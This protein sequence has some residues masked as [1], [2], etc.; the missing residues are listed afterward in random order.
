MSE[1]VRK[2]ER[3]ATRSSLHGRR[4]IEKSVTDGDKEK[5][6]YSADEETSALSTVQTSVSVSGAEGGFEPEDVSETPDSEPH[7]SR[8]EKIEYK[9][10]VGPQHVRH[11]IT[12]TKRH[13]KKVRIRSLEHIRQRLDEP[14]DE[15]YLRM[16]SDNSREKTKVKESYCHEASHRHDIHTTSKIEGDELHT[17]IHKTQI[18]GSGSSGSGMSSPDIPG[19]YETPIVQSY[20]K[21]LALSQ[22]SELSRPRV[23]IKKEVSE[24]TKK[25]KRSA[26]SHFVQETYWKEIQ[27]QGESK[28]AYEETPIVDTISVTSITSTKALSPEYNSEAVERNAEDPVTDGAGALS[29]VVQFEPVQDDLSAPSHEI[30]EEVEFRLGAYPEEPTSSQSSIHE[31]AQSIRTEDLDVRR[32]YRSTQVHLPH[33]DED[34]VVQ[35]TLNIPNLQS[36]IADHADDFSKDRIRTSMVITSDAAKTRTL[37]VE[38]FEDEDSPNES[39]TFLIKPKYK[40]LYSMDVARYSSDSGEDVEAYRGQI[41]QPIGQ[42]VQYAEWETSSSSGSDVDMAELGGR[43]SSRSQESPEFEDHGSRFSG[44]GHDSLGRESTDVM[45]TPE[46]QELDQEQH[47]A[48]AQPDHH[49]QVEEAEGYQSDDGS[50]G[51]SS[52]EILEEVE[53]AEEDRENI[54]EYVSVKEDSNEGLSLSTEQVVEVA[55]EFSSQVEDPS[56]KGIS[57]SQYLD[58]VNGRASNIAAEVVDEATSTAVS[59]TSPAGEGTNEETDATSPTSTDLTTAQQEHQPGVE[60]LVERMLADVFEQSGILIERHYGEIQTEEM[61]ERSSETTDH[62]QQVQGPRYVYESPASGS[63]SESESER[64]PLPELPGA[65]ALYTMRRTRAGASSLGSESLESI[66]TSTLSSSDL[67]LSF[68]STTA[69]SDFEED[70]VLKFRTLSRAQSMSDYEAYQMKHK[71]KTTDDF[72]AEENE[73]YQVHKTKSLPLISGSTDDQEEEPPKEDNLSLS[74]PSLVPEESGEEFPTCTVSQT[75]ITM[76]GI[77]ADG[78]MQTS[79]Q[80]HDTFFGPYEVTERYTYESEIISKSTDLEDGQK[81]QKEIEL[82]AQEVMR[83]EMTQTI[84][85]ISI[86]DDLHLEE[87]TQ[88][89]SKSDPKGQKYEITIHDHL[90]LYIDETDGAHAKEKSVL[91]VPEG[92]E[93]SHKTSS[94]GSSE[95]RKMIIV[96]SVEKLELVEEKSDNTT[97]TDGTGPDDMEGDLVPELRLSFLT[98]EQLGDVD[99][100]DLIAATERIQQLYQSEPRQALLSFPDSDDSRL[101]PIMEEV[102]ETSI[103]PTKKDKVSPASSEELVDILGKI[104]KASSDDAPSQDILQYSSPSDVSSEMDIVE[105]VI[106]DETLLQQSSRHARSSIDRIEELLAEYHDKAEAPDDKKEET[107]D[108]AVKRLQE[109]KMEYK[110]VQKSKPKVD[111]SG[112][113]QSPDALYANLSVREEQHR[114]HTYQTLRAS[115]RLEEDEGD[116]LEPVSYRMRVSQEDDYLEPS[117]TKTENVYED[118]KEDVYDDIKAPI[119][120]EYSKDDNIYEDVVLPKPP[121]L[122][123]PTRKSIKEEH[124]DDED[125]DDVF[126]ERRDDMDKYFKDMSKKTEDGSGD[127]VE[128]PETRRLAG[129]EKEMVIGSPS[130]LPIDI[131]DKTPSDEPL[132]SRR[133][134]LLNDEKRMV[135]KESDDHSDKLNLTGEIHASSDLELHESM[136]IEAEGGPDIGENDEVSTIEVP[137]ARDLRGSFAVDGNLPENIFTPKWDK[138]ITVIEKTSD[139]LTIPAQKGDLERVSTEER[140]SSLGKSISLQRALGK[141]KVV[142]YL[143]EQAGVQSL[144]NALTPSL[145]VETGSDN[146]KEDSP[147]SSTVQSLELVEVPI[148]L[149]DFEAKESVDLVTSTP[150]RPTTPDQTMQHETVVS[151]ALVSPTPSKARVSELTMF[152]DTL[153]SKDSTL[154]RLAHENV[155]DIIGDWTF[156]NLEEHELMKQYQTQDITVSDKPDFEQTSKTVQYPTNEKDDIIVEKSQLSLQSVDYG[157]LMKEPLQLAEHPDRSIDGKGDETDIAIT[158]LERIG[159][160]TVEPGSSMSRDI[161]F[162]SL[163]GETQDVFEDNSDDDA[164]YLEVLPIPTVENDSEDFPKRKTTALPDHVEDGYVVLR[165]IDKSTLEVETKSEDYDQLKKVEDD[166]DYQSSK[167]SEGV[168]SEGDDEYEDYE[169]LNVVRR[170]ILSSSKDEDEYTI[171][172]LTESNKSVIMASESTEPSIQTVG[173]AV[174]TSKKE[175]DDISMESSDS[176]LPSPPPTP[177]PNLHP[178]RPDSGYITIPSSDD[179]YSLRSGESSRFNT[180][181]P[182]VQRVP[183]IANVD[184]TIHDDEQTTEDAPVPKKELE[185]SPWTPTLERKV[186]YERAATKVLDY[187]IDA[188]PDIEE[189]HRDLNISTEDSGWIS[190]SDDESVKEVV[191]PFPAVANQTMQPEDLSQRVWESEKV[192][193]NEEVRFKA[194]L[195]P[196]PGPTQIVFEEDTK[197]YESAESEEGPLEEGLCPLDVTWTPTLERK[198]RYERAIELEDFKMDALPEKEPNFNLSADDTMLSVGSEEMETRDVA[199]PFIPATA[200]LMQSENL[201]QKI[202]DTT[203]EEEMSSEP[204]LKPAPG[205]TQILFEGDTIDYESAES[206]EEHVEPLGDRVCPLDVT[207]TPTLE[208]KAR[209]ERAIK[210]EDYKIDTLPEIGDNQLDLNLSTDDTVVSSEAEEVKI[211][212]VTHPFIAATTERMQSDNLLQRIED[213]TTPEEMSSKLEL[214]PAT[215]KTQILFEEVKEKKVIIIPRVEVSEEEAALPMSNEYIEVLPNDEELVEGVPLQPL[216]SPPTSPFEKVISQ[217]HEYITLISDESL[218]QRESKKHEEE[219]DYEILKPRASQTQHESEVQ[220]DNDYMMVISDETRIQSEKIEMEEKSDYIALIPDES[221]TQLGKGEVEEDHEYI[222]VIPGVYQTQSESTIETEHD[223]IKVITEKGET[224]PGKEDIKEDSEYITV[225]P[226]EVQTQTEKMVEADHEYIKLLPDESEIQPVEDD[227]EYKI[228]LADKSQIKEREQEYI[229]LKADEIQTQVEVKDVRE[230]HEYITLIHDEIPSQPQRKEVQED[231]EYILVSD[232]IQTQPEIKKVKEEEHEYITLISE[233]RGTEADSPKITQLPSSASSESDLEPG[234]VIIKPQS[235]RSERTEQWVQSLPVKVQE[236]EENVE[237]HIEKSTLTAPESTSAQTSSPHWEVLDKEVVI[238]PKDSDLPLM[239]KEEHILQEKVPGHVVETEKPVYVESDAKQ[240]VSTTTLPG[241]IVEALPYSQEM[242]VEHAELEEYEHRAVVP[243]LVTQEETIVPAPPEISPPRSPPAEAVEDDQEH[244]LT[245]DDESPAQEAPPLLKSILKTSQKSF[246]EEDK[247]QIYTLPTLKSSPEFTRLEVKERSSIVIPEEDFPQEAI[248]DAPWPKPLFIEQDSEQMPDVEQFSEKVETMDDDYVMPLSVYDSPMPSLEHAEV[249]EDEAYVQT[250]YDENKSLPSVAYYES[251]PQEI[252]ALE[253]KYNLEEKVNV[254]S[255]V[256][257]PPSPKSGHSPLI[258][259]L[260]RPLPLEKEPKLAEPQSSESLVVEMDTQKESVP[261]VQDTVDDVHD[262]IE[263]IP[264]DQPPTE[265]VPSPPA[266]SPPRSPPVDKDQDLEDHG[267]IEALPDYQSTTQDVPSL[268]KLSPKSPSFDQKVEEVQYDLPVLRPPPDTKPTSLREIIQRKRDYGEEYISDIVIPT[269]VE[270]SPEA[271]QAETQNDVAE[272]QSST[273]TSVSVVYVEEAETMP[274]KEVPYPIT[275]PLTPKLEDSNQ[276]QLLP[277]EESVSQQI[278]SPP[279]PLTIPIKDSESE[280]I[281]FHAH[282]ETP[283]KKT[284]HSPLVSKLRR[285]LPLEKDSKLKEHDDEQSERSYFSYPEDASSKRALQFE[286]PSP[287]LPQIPS[288][289]V[290]APESKP[291]IE[292]NEHSTELF[293]TVQSNEMVDESN[294]ITS[295]PW[296]PAIERV[297][298]SDQEISPP[299][300]LDAKTAVSPSFVFSTKKTQATEPKEKPLLSKPRRALPLEKELESQEIDFVEIIPGKKSKDRDISVEL[301]T[302]KSTFSPLRP[303]LVGRDLKVEE[304]DEA[305]FDDMHGFIDTVP[306]EYRIDMEVPPSPEISPTRS[307]PADKIP[308]IEPADIG[309]EHE[310]VVKSLLKPQTAPTSRPYYK[311]DSKESAQEPSLEVSGQELSDS[312]IPSLPMSLAPS[313]LV[314][315]SQQYTADEDRQS[316]AIVSPSFVF[317]TK[318]SQQKEQKEKPLLSKPRRA[319]PLEKDV[320]LEH[321]YGHSEQAIISTGKE[322]SIVIEEKD[323]EP[324]HDDVLEL[325]YID[326]IPDEYVSEMEIPPLPEISPPRSPPADETE[327][328]DNQYPDRKSV[329]PPLLQPKT[330]KPDYKEVVA[331]RSALPVL[332]PS[333]GYSPISIRDMVDKKVVILSSEESSQEP[334]AVSADNIDDEK[335]ESVPV[336]DTKEQGMV[337]PSFVFSTKKVQSPDIEVSQIDYQS[338]ENKAQTAHSSLI[339]E[340]RKLLPLEKALKPK[341]YEINEVHTEGYEREKLIPEEKDQRR[342][343]LEV[344]EFLPS[345]KVIFSPPQSAKVLP[346]EKSVEIVEPRKLKPIFYDEDKIEIQTGV[347]SFTEPVDIDQGYDVKSETTVP[348]P[349]AYSPPRSPPVEVTIQDF[350]MVTQNEQSLQKSQ[351]YGEDKIDIQTGVT[352]FTESVEF[353]QEALENVEMAIP[354]PPATSPPRSPP[355]EAMH[356]E[357]DFVMVTSDEQSLPQRLVYDE[358]RI[359]IRTDVAR[360]PQSMDLNQE[361]IDNVEMAIPTPLQTSPPRSPPAEVTLHDKNKYVMII[362]EEHSQPEK[363]VLHASVSSTPERFIVHEKLDHEMELAEND[364]EQSSKYDD[365]KKRIPTLYEYI[366]KTPQPDQVQRDSGEVPQRY[367]LPALKPSPK[368]EPTSLR[369]VIERKVVILPKEETPEETEPTFSIESQVA[370]EHHVQAEEL[371]YNVD[372][373]EK[374]LSSG[375]TSPLIMPP[376]EKVQMYE[377]QEHIQISA[378]DENKPQTEYSTTSVSSNVDTSVATALKIEQSLNELDEVLQIGAGQAL[379]VSHQTDTEVMQSQP[380]VIHHIEKEVRLIEPKKQIPISEHSKR[381]EIVQLS[382]LEKTKQIERDFRRLD[383]SVVVS[384]AQEKERETH[385]SPLQ[386]SQFIEEELRL[387]EPKKVNKIDGTVS[388]SEKNKL[389]TMEVAETKSQQVLGSSQKEKSSQLDD[390][391]ILEPP[392]GWAP[393]SL[394][395]VI[396]RNIA[397]SKEKTSEDVVPTQDMTSTKVKVS[398]K[399]I[400]SDDPITDTSATDSRVIVLDVSPNIESSQQTPTHMEEVTSVSLEE[401]LPPL[402]SVEMKQEYQELKYTPELIQVISDSTLP[403]PQPGP[404]LGQHERVTGNEAI[405]SLKLS[406]QDRVVITSDEKKQ[407]AFAKLVSPRPWT[408]PKENLKIVE[409]DPRDQIQKP[410]KAKAPAPPVPSL[411]TKRPAPQ[412]PMG[413]IDIVDLDSVEVLPTSSP[414]DPLKDEPKLVLP[415]MTTV[416]PSPKERDDDIPPLFELVKRM[417]DSTHEYDEGISVQISP[418]EPSGSSSSPL[419]MVM[420]QE[421]HAFAESHPI[422]YSKA[423]EK[424][425]S[426]HA[427]SKRAVS[428]MQSE[429]L[430]EEMAEAVI[431]RDV[432]HQPITPTP[433]RLQ[434]QEHVESSKQSSITESVPVKPGYFQITSSAA[435]SPYKPYKWKDIEVDQEPEEVPKEAPSKIARSLRDVIR[436]AAV[437]EFA[438]GKQFQPVSI[439]DELPNSS[440]ESMEEENYEKLHSKVSQSDSNESVHRY[441]QLIPE[442]IQSSSNESMQGYEIL[443]PFDN[444]LSSLESVPGHSYEKVPHEIIELPSDTSPSTKSEEIKQPLVVADFPKTLTQVKEVTESAPRAMYQQIQEDIELP[445]TTSTVKR[446]EFDEPTLELVAHEAIGKKIVEPTLSQE[447]AEQEMVESI[448]RSSPQELRKREVIESTLLEEVRKQEYVEALPRSSPK[449][450]DAIGSIPSSLSD[451]AKKQEVTESILFE[452]VTKQKVIE[453]IPWT[454]P[455]IKQQEVI[456]TT[457][458][459]SFSPEDKQHEEVQEFITVSE[460]ST[461]ESFPTFSRTDPKEVNIEVHD[462]PVL[463][464]PKTKVPTFYRDFAGKSLE[465]VEK[466]DPLE[467]D[468][469]QEQLAPSSTVEDT[470]VTPVSMEG[471]PVV[472]LFEEVTKQKVI[473]SIPW[474]LPQIKQEEVIET[475]ERAS[476]SPEYKQHEEV[477]EFITVSESSTQESY[478]TFSRTDSKEVNTQVHDSPVLQLPKTKVPTFYR[479]FAGKNLEIVEKDDAL[480]VDSLK[481]QWAPSSTVEDTSVTPVSVEEVPVV[482]ISHQTQESPSSDTAPRSEVLHS[483]TQTSEVHGYVEEHQVI[484]DESERAYPTNERASFFPE[485]EEHKEVQEFISVSETSTQE[486]FPTFSRTDSKE[487]NTQVHDSPVLAFPKTKV[488]T[489]YRDF[490][491]KRLEI[492]EKD[493]TLIGDSLQEQWASSSTVED[494]SVTPANMEEAPV[495]LISHQTQESSSSDTAPRSQVLHTITQTSEVHEYVEELQVIADESERSYPKALSKDPLPVSYY[496]DKYLSGSFQESKEYEEVQRNEDVVEY[497]PQLSQTPES[498]SEKELVSQ[499]QFQSPSVSHSFEESSRMYDSAK[500]ETSENEPERPGPVTLSVPETPTDLLAENIKQRDELPQAGPVTMSIPETPSD[501]LSDSIKQSDKPS[502][503]GPLTISVPEKTTDLLSDS[504]KQGEEISWAGPVTKSVPEIPTDLLSENIKQSDELPQPGPAVMSVPEKPTDLLSDNLKQYDEVSRPGPVIMSLPE[505]PTDLLSDNKRRSDEFTQPGPVIMSVPETPTDLL[506]DNSRQSDELIQPGP[507]TVSVPETPID[508]LS[509]NRRRS[510]SSRQSSFSS[511]SEK[512]VVIISKDESQSDTTYQTSSKKRSR[513][514]SPLGTPPSKTLKGFPSPRPTNRS[515]PPPKHTLSDDELDS[516]TVVPRALKRPSVNEDV[517]KVPSSSP[518]RTRESIIKGE[519]PSPVAS[520]KRT[521][522]SEKFVMTGDSSFQ[523]ASYEESFV[524]VQEDHVVPRKIERTV[525]TLEEDAKEYQLKV[526]SQQA[527]PDIEKGVDVSSQVVAD[528]ERNEIISPHIVPELERAVKP[529]ERAFPVQERDTQSPEPHEAVKADLSQQ[530]VPDLEL[531]PNAPRQVF[532]SDEEIDTHMFSDT[533]S[534]PEDLQ[535]EAEDAIV[536]TKVTKNLEDWPVTGS[537][538]VSAMI[539]TRP[540]YRM[541]DEELESDEDRLSGGESRIDGEFV[542]FTDTGTVAKFESTDADM[543]RYITLLPGDDELWAKENDDDLEVSIRREKVLAEWRKRKMREHEFDILPKDTILLARTS[544]ASNSEHRWRVI[545]LDHTKSLRDALTYASS[546]SGSEVSARD[547]LM[548]DDYELHWDPK[549][550]PADSSSLDPLLEGLAKKG[551]F[552]LSQGE[553]LDFSQSERHAFTETYVNTTLPASEDQADFSRSRV[554]STIGDVDNIEFFQD[555]TVELSTEGHI[556]QES[557]IHVEEKEVGE[558]AKVQDIQTA[559]DVKSKA[560]QISEQKR[561]LEIERR[562]RER[563]LNQDFD[564]LPQDDIITYGSEF[565]LSDEEIK[566]QSLPNDHSKSLRDALNYYAQSI[567]LSRSARKKVEEFFDGPERRPVV[568]RKKSPSH[569]VETSLSREASLKSSSSG[570]SLNEDELEMGRARGHQARK[571]KRPHRSSKKS[572][573]SRSLR[574]ETQ[575]HSDERDSLAYELSFE[576]EKSLIHDQ[577]LGVDGD[578]NETG[579]YDMTQAPTTLKASGRKA[580]ESLVPPIPLQ[581][582]PAAGARYSQMDSDYHVDSEIPSDILDQS[583]LSS[584]FEP[585]ERRATFISMDASMEEAAPSP[586]R[587]KMAPEHPS[588]ITAS[589]FGVGTMVSESHTSTSTVDRSIRTRGVQRPTPVS[590]ADWGISTKGAEY[591]PDTHITASDF[592]V[593]TRGDEQVTSITTTEQGVRSKD[594]EYLPNI[595]ATDFGYQ[596]RGTEFSPIAASD[597]GL[598]TIDSEHTQNITARN[599]GYQIKDTEQFSPIT[600]SDWG[601]RTIDSEHSQNI[602]ARDFGYQIKDTE[603]FSPITSPDWGFRTMGSEYSPNI[604]AR[605]FGYQTKDTE[606]FSPIDTSNWILKAKDSELSPN[607]TASDFGYMTRGVEQFS[608]ISA[609]D[610]GMRTLGAEQLGGMAIQ[611]QTSITATDFGVRANATDQL[612]TIGGTEQLFVSTTDWGARSMVSGPSSPINAIDWRARSRIS[613]QMSPIY[614]SDWGARTRIAGQTSPIYATDWGASTRHPNPRQLSSP[615]TVTD[616]GSRTRVRVGEGHSSSRQKE[617]ALDRVSVL[618][619]DKLVPFESLDSSDETDEVV[620]FTTTKASFDESFMSSGSSPMQHSIPQVNVVPFD[621]DC[622]FESFHSGSYIEVSSSDSEEMRKRL[623]SS[624]EGDK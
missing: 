199:Q 214:R 297:M 267:F 580:T 507:V 481:E 201:L 242:H 148:D 65:R 241:K 569:R 386:T 39:G 265:S 466:D 256:D 224:E 227:R 275:K 246:S 477:Q 28:Q 153:K 120:K 154:S 311:E 84:P 244:M 70:E 489:F 135:V 516:A 78:K 584:T 436:G 367:D 191:H 259:K 323:R 47:L 126:M 522:K 564:I 283:T 558:S 218:T 116:Y 254:Q 298:L 492:V 563:Y 554:D 447:A 577:G 56:P 525:S 478:P 354:T 600:A 281:E 602:I 176:S 415:E 594:S 317:T 435:T 508:L 495:V 193:V 526:I 497:H 605:D 618:P 309:D 171:L 166:E 196:A 589:D 303:L 545:P 469:L 465:I 613:G 163:L 20:M 125:E 121:S 595:T 454:L 253:E 406:S 178:I 128:S 77:E 58:E 26:D 377:D 306:V 345:K 418:S 568:Y 48:E 2:E 103:H 403:K 114:E 553:S 337:S 506:P 133:R 500:T 216:S 111:E 502:L 33:N 461:Q 64:Q 329:K 15:Q 228:I 225:I 456:D 49:L 168:A 498:L 596:T 79:P 549:A 235:E 29:P 67:A 173:E 517:S 356:D 524:E 358:D 412:P 12:H 482:L 257:V 80:K 444:Q 164:G 138:D 324:I 238:V 588:F 372:H 232:E 336:L 544:T 87:Q 219:S 365:T 339:S 608:P 606:Q 160:L 7:P 561:R 340:P 409:R 321:D 429:D 376:L 567:G 237:T 385:L 333:P 458:R 357:L 464:L 230:D 143:E 609:T 391:P 248:P 488:P 448:P 150:A 401:S 432:S 129:Q 211:R 282:V 480:E 234:Y 395:D 380:E 328:I 13:N 162:A 17:T 532:S 69:D 400:S 439:N 312:V 578:D 92:S 95:S 183:S 583:F 260:R 562:R 294:L 390:L 46:L 590:A 206:E 109:L 104:E 123:K 185:G 25:E 10:Q 509:D 582:D 585:E 455:Q 122:G 68:D 410:K 565:R 619:N 204:E 140:E 212:D 205:Q 251:S 543:H 181:S 292:Q 490:A 408:L 487:V 75:H 375:I 1:R 441:Q 136:F 99:E 157:A 170:P 592:V 550:F 34:S 468:S 249:Y 289:S 467:V 137:P 397:L 534:E 470:S 100:E 207:W 11:E 83:V 382:P 74:M 475:T 586:S 315:E 451:E 424:I 202:E 425:L 491:G 318:K 504:I 474:T 446:L 501:L 167:A 351:I 405:T 90:E 434:V 293:E 437:V 277:L 188:L 243:D 347:A 624:P 493:D 499:H 557:G 149:E 71:H 86:E 81:N 611:P 615:I 115:S 598:R 217:E 431:Q 443:R 402:Q 322:I 552:T 310:Q 215:G 510:I 240:P 172:S 175:D 616:W 326:V 531:E 623:A 575:T 139:S 344:R 316:Q 37:S 574:P 239:D 119:S 459:A 141:E 571:Q 268:L 88:E 286:E 421:D 513:E 527:V 404:T 473:E 463:E 529:S 118:I 208:R 273:V 252:S 94:S 362:P 184:M 158:R 617:L 601:L 6:H 541:S 302:S 622:S 346:Q 197:D 38:E 514:S 192:P 284:A 442:Y 374:V 349:P 222:Q 106:T 363:P 61:E 449:E 422:S 9:Q 278:A 51:F 32:V 361:P 335:Q 72:Y 102:V 14:M 210:L 285:Q 290:S 263:V 559:T 35:R 147:V 599:F 5:V 371:S 63:D 353:N 438:P 398:E 105:S 338:S 378:D 342:R 82:P 566:K 548:Q 73:G 24:S 614:A 546:V 518:K 360:F 364:D 195:K 42:V 3:D 266:L 417:K 476:S 36:V 274:S 8:E 528:L 414:T 604:S 369:E 379:T 503:P 30:F 288:Q 93:Q 156:A 445:S 381:V 494:T 370:K 146:S 44:R 276:R 262:Y 392:P 296:S 21:V 313:V 113:T 98:E 420:V 319:L 325:E 203:S 159:S 269:L 393:G 419:E 343:S 327:V 457:E 352:R 621:P 127:E 209:Y 587:R 515:P 542:V 472:L 177:P 174:F 152:D 620:A 462:S 233:S 97:D 433:E 96:E 22:A 440:T 314:P 593:R 368:Y 180:L 27:T 161:S 450:E 142:E 144:P 40:S 460:S 579:F 331:Q 43:D 54:S 23:K 299:V 304:Q 4:G 572:S 597:W 165:P 236:E 427:V 179:Y 169:T 576:S 155:Q 130:I 334:S 483:I 556:S 307:P 182:Q 426:D 272:H 308:M 537:S 305:K 258:S 332:K 610:W 536:E 373:K 570:D 271:T 131:K 16:T 291:D 341:D 521:R 91:E 366:R 413:D 247:T 479:D 85:S 45:V 117:S 261:T 270:Q 581:E 255:T 535:S 560:V 603:Q 551:D 187:K 66:Q 396:Q 486:S 416:L 134:T 231:S 300:D 573:P 124:Y 50:S 533:Y 540:R 110:E 399:P 387:F 530:I 264:V 245:L 505:T 428:S 107:V 89:S 484:A 383:K 190:E 407:E 213:T 59:Q 512:K 384:S 57:Y 221:Q 250:V 430:T 53:R 31:L 330:S 453:S 226:D 194:E 151:F 60:V 350:V 496:E 189:R 198:A 320:I 301:G 279:S 186:R 511:I 348:S 523:I 287:S 519:S 132:S 359:E 229:S 591:P 538:G 355:A 62:D 76:L 394:M 220:E 108:P 145:Q 389:V 52:E 388:I 112:D 223:Y 520:P 411:S 200:E 18:Y 539:L 547:S 452:E 607:I 55:P 423:L 555:E 101:S 280:Y 295:Q 471:A 485:H 612:S 19:D 41:P